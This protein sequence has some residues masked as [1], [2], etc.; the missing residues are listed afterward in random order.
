MAA[1]SGT[2]VTSQKVCECYREKLRTEE[3]NK[4]LIGT[5][6]TG[7][8]AWHWAAKRDNSEILKRVWECAK[9]KPKQRRLI[10][11]Y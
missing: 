7:K 9:G 1:I 5:D 3:I 10:S 8:A 6:K 2:S 4:S 11:I